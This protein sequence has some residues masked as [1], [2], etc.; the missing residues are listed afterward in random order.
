MDVKVNING[1]EKNKNEIIYNN[2]INTMEDMNISK[3]EQIEYLKQKITYLENTS[4]EKTT[5]IATILIGFIMLLFGVYLMSININIYGAILILVSFI[6]VTTKL[7]LMIKKL[8][9][10]CKDSKFDSVEQLRK[11]LNL[12]L[13]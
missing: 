2:I 5:L 10:S 11:I 1:T 8:Q 7:V 4:K 13:K 9:A 6:V 3:Q 12:K